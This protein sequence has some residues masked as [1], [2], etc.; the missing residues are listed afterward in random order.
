MPGPGSY[1]IGDE[2][3]AEVLDVMESGHVSRYG[4]LDDPSFKGKVLAFEKEF[5]AFTGARFC[6]AT[7]S[8]TSTLLISLRAIG[9][10]EG[11]EVIV[12]T[13]TFIASYGAPIFL[14]AVP[15]LTDIDESLCIDPEDIERRITPRTKAIMPVHIIGNPCDMDAV[16]DVANRHGI[17]VVE[18]CCQACGA[19]YK[20]KSVGRF[21]LLGGFS[22]NIYK[23]ITA[24]DGG[25]L[26]TD[27]EELFAH[28]FGMT[29]QGYKKKGGRLGPAP[30][31][32]LGL[33]FRITELTGAVALAQTRK[34]QGIL[35]TLRRKKARLKDAIGEITGMQYRR[36][37]DEAGECGTVLTVTFDDAGR[38]ARVAQALDTVTVDDTGWHVYSNMDQ[39]N[40]HLA[41]LGRPHSLGAYPR[42]DDILRRSINLSVGVV[43]AGLGTAFGIDINSSDEEIDAVAERF[44]TTSEAN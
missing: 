32:V 40:Q 37:N 21:G 23:T 16:M 1:R 14:G 33:N 41:D 17:P 29:D 13:Y 19:F 7:S 15:V 43:D 22:L 6:Q 11:D 42:S 39:I 35:E 9:V 3:R 25:M 2:E 18:D 5:A 44:R 34:L 28:A 4:D 20:G 31:S 36:L 26:I 30:P 38:A 8:G 10:G 27:D 24:G 12:P